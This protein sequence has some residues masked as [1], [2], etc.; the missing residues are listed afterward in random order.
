MYTFTRT[1]ARRDAGRKA[2]SKQRYVEGGA[3]VVAPACG[4]A[5]THYL[6]FVEGGGCIL[7]SFGRRAMYSLAGERKKGRKGEGGGLGC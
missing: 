3:P 2:E 5:S 4:V 1:R 7:Y 6:H